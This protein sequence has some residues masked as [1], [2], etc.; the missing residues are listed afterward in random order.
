ML[1]II[2]KIFG[3]KNTVA[4]TSYEKLQSKI[5]KW[6]TEGV[7][8]ALYELPEAISF[9]DYFWKKVIQLYKETRA[10][11]HERA[12]AVFWADGELVLT[13]TVRGSTKSVQTKNQIKVSYEPILRNN[14]YEY[15]RRKIIVDE[16]TYSEKEVYYKKVPK[17]IASPLYLFN[18]HTHPPHEIGTG[19]GVSSS[20][21]AGDYVGLKEYGYWSAQDIKSLVL[22]NAIVTGLITDTFHFIIRTNKTPS[23]VDF[24]EDSKINKKFLSEE[25]YLAV[26]TGRFGEKI[27]RES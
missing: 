2:Q 10:D 12:I 11:G 8:P 18:M 26:Y 22:S 23:S 19:Y 5:T 16:K 13:D 24:L 7:Y 1:K 21:L 9:P 27:V 20:Q 25:L 3:T 4:T 6:K 17:K 15:Y 14:K